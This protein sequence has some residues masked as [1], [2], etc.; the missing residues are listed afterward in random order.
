MHFWSIFSSFLYVLFIWWQLF[1]I[2][3]VLFVFSIHLGCFSDPG[4]VP[5]NAFYLPDALEDEKLL[6]CTKCDAY[7][8]PRAH[9]CSQCNR[10]IIRM[11]HHCPWINNCVGFK[12]MKFFVL[13]LGYVI[14]LCVYTF[15]LD[16]Y[17]LVYSYKHVTYEDLPGRNQYGLWVPSYYRNYAYIKFSCFILLL[18]KFNDDWCADNNSNKH[19]LY[20]CLLMM[21]NSDW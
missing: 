14:S 6:Y 15:L 13:F 16:L 8:P 12:N 1:L 9:H 19:D 20:I 7:K 10:C 3:D 11:D 17:R 4:S 21:M 5:S 2:C 18:Y